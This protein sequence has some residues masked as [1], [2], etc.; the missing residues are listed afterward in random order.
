MCCIAQST[1]PSPEVSY[2]V[3]PHVIGAHNA[4]ALTPGMNSEISR[5]N[6]GPD[7]TC[8]QETALLKK[9]NNNLETEPKE[10]VCRL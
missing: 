10:Q 6:S 3:I 4:K 9:N 7:P 8:S 2:A 5:R 1:A